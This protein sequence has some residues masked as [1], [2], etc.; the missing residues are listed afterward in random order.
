MKLTLDYSGLDALV[1]QKGERLEEIEDLLITEEDSAERFGE[2]TE[3][4]AARTTAMSA[5][6]V[7]QKIGLERQKAELVEHLAK[8]DREYQAYLRQLG[9]WTNREKEIRG[10]DHN[11]AADSVKGLEKELEKIGA[12]YP[13]NLRIAR[14]EQ[15]RFSKEVFQKKRNLT[16]FY[17]T[18]KQSMDTEI[19]KC[20]DDLDDY[21]IS[22]EAGL[23]FDP[24]FIDTFLRF[25]NQGVRGSFYGVEEG[26]AMLQVF[27]DA[28]DDW[29]NET[30]VF[31]ALKAIVDALH[32]DKRD[33]LSSTED[34]SRDVF[35]QMKNQNVPVV[36]LYDYLFGFDYL[37]T[38]YDLKVDQKDLSELSPGERG[39]LLL[40]FYFML[41]RQ[42]HSFGHRP[43]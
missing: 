27:C 9:I 29:E 13:K 14:A 22:I 39:G 1:A 4:Q 19:A 3:V 6:I 34:K 2:G 38:K 40:I 35:K 7:C 30:E 20:R 10:D 37:N 12:V 21:T 15:A 41:D 42:G 33:D 17:D 5:S 11:P 43:A 8:P 24:S 16:G 31:D 23:R 36:E 32:I 28:V 18:I 25:I 26:R